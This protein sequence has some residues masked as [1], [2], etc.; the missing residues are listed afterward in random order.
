MR[1]GGGPLAAPRIAI[2]M[3]EP[4]GIGP[5]VTLK[6]LTAAPLRHRVDPLLLGD[7][8]VLRDAAERLDLPLRFCADGEAAGRGAVA[9]RAVSSLQA[10]ERVPGRPCRAGGEAAFQAIVAG[11]RA[12][13]RGEAAALV[14]AP[15]SKANIAAAG[16]DFPGH[17]ELLTELSGARR[18]RMMMAGPRL[19][20]VLATTHVA[21]RRVPSLLDAELVGDTIA[22]TARALTDLF[23]I[24]RPRLA[25]CGLNPHAGE[26][27]LF[28]R[29]ETAVI[30]PAVRAAR[31]RGIRAEGPLPADSVFAH[32]AAGGY[33]A[34]VC[35]YHDQGLA[36]FKLLHFEDGVNV[37]LGLPFVRTS[38]DHGTAYDIAGKGT[39]NP[40]SMIAAIAL[41]AELAAR[42]AAASRK[43][44]RPRRAGAN[45]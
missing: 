30:A 1:R 10:R 19:R 33:D 6:A 22:V 44:Q 2:S 20:V 17:T 35:M 42:R 27:G 24:A 31:R 23:G 43:P 34:V 41:A 26:G 29:E 37:T 36:P 38:P 14:T 18:V 8:E 12:V 13:Q 25:V 32:A 15:I 45:G 5:E 40:A 11:T 21:L 4:A 3:G 28:G 9:V 7:V 39:A 16:H